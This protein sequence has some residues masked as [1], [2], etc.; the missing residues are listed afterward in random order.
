MLGRGRP[1]NALA[2]TEDER[3]DTAT[4]VREVT[5]DF[6]PKASRTNAAMMLAATG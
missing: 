2:A 3:E 5:A 6:N 1:L 4:H